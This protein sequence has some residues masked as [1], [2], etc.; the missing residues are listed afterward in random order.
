M[1]LQMVDVVSHWQ[2]DFINGYFFGFKVQHD[3]LLFHGFCTKNEV[4]LR[5]TILNGLADG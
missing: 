5:L 3:T 4:I 1:P 2:G